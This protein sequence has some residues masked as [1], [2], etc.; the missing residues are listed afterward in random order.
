MTLLAL[1]VV[2]AFV[3]LGF[4][5]LHRA[6]EKQ[7][8]LTA[9]A[10]GQQS[11]VDLRAANSGQLPRYQRVRVS[12]NFDS[13]HQL[14]LDNMPSHN[15]RAGFRVLTPLKQS[16]GHLVLVDRGWVAMGTSR[17]TLPDIQVAPTERTLTGQW[18]QPPEPGVRLGGPLEIPATWPKLLNFPRQ[19]DLD[20]IYGSSLLPGIVLLDPKD[21]DGYERVWQAHFGFGPERHIAY[22]VQWFALAVAV[23]V[24]FVVVNCKSRSS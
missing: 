17:T 19:T 5:Q 13:A 20:S 18:D 1:V 10:A 3:R 7:A 9:F 11:L 24:T 8:L 2:L 4:W 15:G 23:V 6:D 21:D 14:L 12:G 16:D 22:A